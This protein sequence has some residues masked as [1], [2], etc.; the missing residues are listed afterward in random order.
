MSVK[1]GTEQIRAVGVFEQITKVHVRDCLIDNENAYFLVEAGKMGVAIGKN[2]I[3]IKNVS[4]ILGKNV[5][6]FEYADNA[7][8]LVRNL[9]PNLKSADFGGKGVTVS[10]SP[11]DRSTVIG[12]NGRNIKA[13]REFLDRHYQIKNLRLK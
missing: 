2:G 7:E 4:R 8:N 10:I 9:I 5:K 12:K 1:L 11:A 13:I 3:T 6:I